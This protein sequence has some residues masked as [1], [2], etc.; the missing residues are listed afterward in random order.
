[1]VIVER[2]RVRERL[3]KTCICIEKGTVRQRTGK[4]GMQKERMKTS[5][6]WETNFKLFS[7]IAGFMLLGLGGVHFL[8][9]EWRLAPYGVF[10]LILD[11]VLVILTSCEHGFFLP[12]LSLSLCHSL[13]VCF[14]LVFVILFAWN[15]S[16]FQVRC[17]MAFSLRMVILTLFVNS[18]VSRSF[19]RW[20]YEKITLNRVRERVQLKVK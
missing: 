19:F 5:T 18:T 16:H 2:Q 10:H 20:L 15:S 8:P 1:M 12:S 6:K 11:I 9:S 14:F 17:V 3:Q 4:D 7:F 13:S